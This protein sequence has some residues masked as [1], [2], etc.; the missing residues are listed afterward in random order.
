MEKAFIFQEICFKV[1]ILKTFK[2]SRV[3]VTIKHDDLS[4]GKLIWKSL[5]PFFK[6]NLCS[7]WKTALSCVIVQILFILSIPLFKYLYS[8]IC[9]NGMYRT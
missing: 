5:E 3:I 7:H 6:G 9:D 2:T 1:L 8:L 4:N